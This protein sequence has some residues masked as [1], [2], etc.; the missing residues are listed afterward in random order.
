MEKM[1]I[2]K[3]LLSDCS[4]LLIALENCDVYEIDATDVIDLYCEVEQIGKSER[5]YRAKDGFIKIS[6]NASQNK[7]RS[8]VST[9]LDCPLKERLAMCGGVDMTLFSL[10]RKQ[11]RDIDVYVPYEPLE[12]VVRRRELELSNCPSLEIDDEGNMTIAFGKSSTQPK[13]KDNK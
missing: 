8:G 9:E 7:E 3:E 12:G 4:A 6:A 10:R 2:N 11:E 13:R 1:I 5:E